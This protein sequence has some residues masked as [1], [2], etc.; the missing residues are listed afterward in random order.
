MQGLSFEDL[1]LGQSASMTRSVSEADI[2]AFAAV[3]GDNNPVHLDD[4][5][6]QTTMFKEIGRAHV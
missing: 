5:F 4:A 1:S 3:S 6:A 2:V